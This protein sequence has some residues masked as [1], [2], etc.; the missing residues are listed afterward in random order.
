MIFGMTQ[1]EKCC[2]WQGVSLNLAAVMEYL[3]QFV[4]GMETEILC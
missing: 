4:L 1:R 3:P 2:K